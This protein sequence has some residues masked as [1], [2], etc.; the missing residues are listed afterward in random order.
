MTST[1]SS[2]PVAQIDDVSTVQIHSNNRLKLP[3]LI[4]VAC[5]VAL[6]AAT[7]RHAA[8]TAIP[9][10]LLGSIA[11]GAAHVS[12]EPLI[13]AALIAATIGGGILLG[14]LC[15]TDGRM[16]ALIVGVLLV[17]VL[18][19]SLRPEWV[20]LTPL[21][22]TQNSRFWG[23]G[24]QLETLLL[25]PFSWVPFSPG[26]GSVASASPAS[27]WSRSCSSP[28]TGSA[29]TE[30]ARSS[31]VSRSLCSARGRCASACAASS[32]SSSSR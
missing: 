12:S 19:F 25:A 22:P 23:V 6:L 14:R 20:A 9:A 30:A 1:G 10:A 29:R 7:R 18:L 16:L 32:P 8:M 11:L 21:G 13:L 24:N 4:I 26:A 5:A 31:S 15:T 28:T 3:A 27:R 2:T 17:H